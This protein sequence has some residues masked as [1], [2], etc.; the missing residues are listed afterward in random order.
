MRQRER[1]ATSFGS[2]GLNQE[3]HLGVL[4][5]DNELGGGISSHCLFHVANHGVELDART[6]SC[7]RAA[8]G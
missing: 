6:R 5:E 2:I 3:T 7:R 1:E 8:C 4:A